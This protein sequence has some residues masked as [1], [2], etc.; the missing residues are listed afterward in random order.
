MKTTNNILIIILPM[1]V[2][3][4][5]G[6]CSIRHYFPAEGILTEDRYAI[7]RSDSLLI[8]V[9]PTSYNGNY[10]SLNNRFFPVFIRI[11]NNSGNRINIP[12]SAFSVITIDQQYD[13]VP[14]Q[15]ILASLRQNLFLEET[16]DI[17]Q[18]SSPYPNPLDETRTQD[19]Y[20]EMVNKSFS[21][22]DLL[23][24]G[25]KEGYLFYNKAISYGNSFSFD[26][27][28]KTILFE[29]K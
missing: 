9:K 8:A 24:G 25:I 4:L 18:P 13:P 26:A 3:L 12:E 10:Q 20:F 1:V 16:R 28:G 22:G 6:A 17:F 29:K 19:I 21:Y 2:F 5:S 14:I 23:P 15:F 27:L 7:I 11:K